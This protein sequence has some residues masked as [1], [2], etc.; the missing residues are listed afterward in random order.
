L[1]TL[2][3]SLTFCD[4]CIVSIDSSFRARNY[5]FLVLR[6]NAPLMSFSSLSYLALLRMLSSSYYSF[7]ANL[8]LNSL[9]SSEMRSHLFLRRLTS[10]IS[11]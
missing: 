2:R 11:C 7:W 9:F 8:R 1:L 6:L 5:W 10:P 3:I 4:N